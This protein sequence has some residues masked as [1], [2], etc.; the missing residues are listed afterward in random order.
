MAPAIPVSRHPLSVTD[1]SAEVPS[2]RIAGWITW[3]IAVGPLW[4]LV[5]REPA[6]ILNLRVLAAFAGGLVFAL[7]FFSDQGRGLARAALQVFGG[8]VAIVAVPFPLPGA[9]TPA[10][11]CVVAIPPLVFAGRERLALAALV[12]QTVVLAWV[13][14][15]HMNGAAG[16]GLFVGAAVGFQAFVLGVARI[17]AREVR[18]RRELA[19][20]LGELSAAQAVIAADE[21]L[22]ERVRIARDLHDAIGHHL[23]TLSL[24]LDLARRQAPDEARR[25]IAMAHSVCRVLLTELRDVLGDVRSADGDELRASLR[26]LVARIPGLAIDLDVDLSRDE[27]GEPARIDPD[28]A[29]LV[30]RVVQECLTNVLRHAAARHVQVCVER[31]AG[32]LRGEVA[33]DG[34]GSASPRP[35][36]GLAGLARRLEALGGEL[37]VTEGSPGT[38]VRWTVPAAGVEVLR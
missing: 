25:T 1:V 23:T 12:G 15:P 3:A 17:A 2:V 20:A 30:V 31:V 24:H 18:A 21:R 5:L 8:A 35:G 28:V 16:A 11:L 13:Y 37:V 22:G 33:D 14:S 19:T 7:G 10:L 29:R 6:S 32:S 36:G 4:L 9:P 27:T 34:R 38:V 26:E